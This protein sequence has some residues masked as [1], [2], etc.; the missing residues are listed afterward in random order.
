MS[1]VD[2]KKVFYDYFIEECYEVGF[3]FEGWEVK[4][5]CVGCFNFKELYVVLKD[6]E[7]FLIGCYISFL[8]MVFIYVYV[9]LMCSCK[10]LLNKKEINKL[11]G[12]VECVGY[13]LVLIDLYFK[14]GCIKLEV[15]LVK[16]K[17]QY[18]KCEIEKKCDWDCEKVCLMWSK[19]QFIYVGFL[20]LEM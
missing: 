1:I 16:G 12:S 4:V 8:I 18:D 5:I 6:G 14:C 9:D 20:Q 15:G 3:V 11:I 13:V 7:V 10:L 17:K 2:N 19:V